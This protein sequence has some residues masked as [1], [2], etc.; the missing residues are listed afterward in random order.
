MGGRV[1]TRVGVGALYGSSRTI[2]RYYT[3]HGT[4]ARE[5]G[6][7]VIVKRDYVSCALISE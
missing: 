7:N 6:Y 1:E 4:M 3:R 5:Y 2:N